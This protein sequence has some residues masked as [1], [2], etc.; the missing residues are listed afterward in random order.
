MKIDKQFITL[1][2]NRP[3]RKLKAVNGIVVHWIGVP[4]ARAQVIRDNFQ[5]GGRQGSAQFIID[6]NDGTIIQTMPETEVAIHVGSNTYKPMKYQLIGNAKPNDYLIGI[7][8]CVGEKSIPDDYSN[9]KKYPN[10]GKPSDVLYRALIELCADLCNRHELDPLTQLYRHYDF[11]GKPCHVWFVNHTDKWAAFKREV[12][13]AM[14][15]LDEQLK[16]K[17][18]LADETANYI[19]NYK[20]GTSLAEKLLQGEKVFAA[21]TVR[22][23]E[24]YKYR[25]ALEKKL[26]L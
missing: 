19:L 24:K 20:Y 14:M 9:G 13:A 17:F 26:G 4:C 23:L 16:I 8:C 5:R 2:M 1:P 11:T 7:E 10:M 3:G 22:Y 18:N 25:A 21:D 6:Y 12:K 15:P